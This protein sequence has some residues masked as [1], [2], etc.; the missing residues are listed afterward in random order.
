MNSSIEKI[1]HQ[2]NSIDSLWYYILTALIFMIVGLAS[3][4][5]GL[6]VFA[7]GS[8]DYDNGKENND[9]DLQSK[10]SGEI[11]A[12]LVIQEL[13]TPLFLFSIGI[14]LIG[15]LRSKIQV[16]EI[17]CS[18]CN[19]SN[20]KSY[21]FCHYCGLD[22][23]RGKNNECPEC[24]NPVLRGQEFCSYCG[25]ELEWTRTEKKEETDN[26]GN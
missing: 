20:L 22:L 4:L 23:R 18:K 17:L 16:A 9:T 2:K 24:K 8:S 14:L 25:T 11:F 1:D 10:G 26:E 12:G 19:H 7:V 15:L 13:T 5:I 21:R 3:P 6:A